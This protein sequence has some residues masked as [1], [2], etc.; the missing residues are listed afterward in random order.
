MTE[1]FPPKDTSKNEFETT[2]QILRQTIAAW[3]KTSGRTPIPLPRFGTAEWSR[4]QRNTSNRPL[5]LQMAAI[6]AC[7]KGDASQLPAWGRSDLLIAAVEREREYIRIQC[8]PPAGRTGL[9]DVM[10]ITTAVL[11]LTGLCIIQ[12]RRW[13]TLLREEIDLSDYPG[14]QPGEVEERRKVIFD[15]RS[16]DPDGSESTP[17]APDILAEA[18]TAIVLRQDRK[19]PKE[20][21]LRAAELSGTVT[22]AKLLR[23]VQD[24]QGFET[25]GDVSQWLDTLIAHRPF[26]ELLA[27][28]RLIPEQTVSLRA[29]ATA[30]CRRV[31]DLWNSQQSTLPER[32]WVLIQLGMHLD[33]THRQQASEEGLLKTQEAVAICE[34]LANGNEDEIMR[35]LARGYHYL[36]RCHESLGQRA[37]CVSAVRKAVEVREKLAEKEWLVYGPELGRSLNNLSNALDLQ[38]HD[39]EALKAAER[40]A[41]IAKEFADRNWQLY[42][43]DL[44]PSYNNL[45]KRLRKAGRFRDALPPIRL[46]AEVREELARGNPDEFA[47]ALLLSLENL[48]ELELQLGLKTEAMNTALKEVEFYD[49]LASRNRQR[50]QI[51]YLNALRRVAR[52]AQ[53]C[54]RFE[55]AMEFAR[56]EVAILRLVLAEDSAYRVRLAQSL[57]DLGFLVSQ[58]G[59]HAEALGATLEALRMREEIAEDSFAEVG[60]DLAWS[61]ANASAQL[62]ELGRPD[63]ALGFKKKEAEARAK[64]L[65]MGGAADKEPLAVTWVS[66]SSQYGRIRDYDTGIIA[67]RKAVEF[68]EQ[69]HRGSGARDDWTLMMAKNNLAYCLTQVGRSVEALPVAE[70]LRAFLDSMSPEARQVKQLE[71][72]QLSE[73]V[74]GVYR[75]LGRLTEAAKLSSQAID[76]YEALDGE[77]LAANAGDYAE[78]W[79]T[80]GTIARAAGDGIKAHHC[81]YRAVKAL[82]NSSPKDRKQETWL[83]N[84]LWLDYRQSCEALGLTPDVSIQPMV[85]G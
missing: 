75:D 70:E 58:V 76:A 55:Q 5:Y 34:G 47:A 2:E 54:G 38:G 53:Q 81:F 13:R 1:L 66:I 73:S 79:H 41:Q 31:L 62:N 23:L 30:L 78:V 32:A 72:G 33:Q 77:T 22:W 46:S 45:G 8:E 56:R 17:I 19:P 15:L 44:G 21:L 57:H 27:V 80:D 42:A 69:S 26:D 9:R 14:L 28:V 39:E 11:C 43:S 36:G 52:L 29:F 7:D 4:I 40:S 82:G 67:A 59:E 25:F 3:A 74:A 64:L 85:E 16:S 60:E 84:K 50:F 10:E 71:Y 24:L 83:M 48:V 49:D 68:A 61:Y 20:R 35:L 12:D 37:E 63:E 18:F 51:G 6:H 65:E